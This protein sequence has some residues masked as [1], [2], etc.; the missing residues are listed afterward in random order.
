MTLLNNVSVNA[1]KEADSVTNQIFL[2]LCIYHKKRMETSLT[3][4]QI[5]RH[6]KRAKVATIVDTTE[7]DKNDKVKPVKLK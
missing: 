3:L 7:E 6:R 4:E 2:S 5:A 1:A